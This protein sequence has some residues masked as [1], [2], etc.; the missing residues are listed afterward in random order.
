MV[1]P[2]IIS[3]VAL[4][5]ASRSRSATRAVPSEAGNACRGDLP[6]APT[7][8]TGSDHQSGATR[9]F[10]QPEASQDQRRA[11]I[12]AEAL[13][14]AIAKGREPAEPST[15][16]EQSKVDAEREGSALTGLQSP[17]L[18]VPAWCID[19]VPIEPPLGWDVNAVPD[20][21]FPQ[22][23]S[24]SAMKEGKEEWAAQ[25]A[26]EDCNDAPIPKAERNKSNG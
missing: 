12:E 21:G 23:Q 26:D 15:Y 14:A 9:P 13:A 5:E 17:V 4:P 7:P 1:G 3:R 2:S 11:I 6:E 20:L 19:P 18:P 22:T 24:Q 8:M 25:A 10:N 16:F